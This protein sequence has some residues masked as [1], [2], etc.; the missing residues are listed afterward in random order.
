MTS[1]Q[2]K[3]FLTVAKMLSFT[4][5]AKSLYMAQPALSKQISAFEKELQMQLFDR[6]KRSVKLTKQGEI[7]YEELSA[8]WR[9]ME[10]VVEMAKNIDKM[11]NAKMKVGV[12]ADDLASN[13]LPKIV[14]E[15]GRSMPEAE[16]DVQIQN[17]SV[18]RTGLDDGTF[19]LVLMMDFEIKDREDIYSDRLAARQLEF[20]IGK[21]S[22]LVRNGEPI[23]YETLSKEAF[24]AVSDDNF[25]IVDKWFQKKREGLG[26]NPREILYAPNVA[27]QRLWLGAGKGAALV[28][29]KNTPWLKD[30]VRVID[31]PVGDTNWLCAAWKKE[32]ENP[33]IH[34]FLEIAQDI[35]A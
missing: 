6:T 22:E 28:D 4:E 7:M 13:A 21:E 18:L 12:V 31:L 2:I 11:R 27:T 19:D 9:R 32:N 17:S 23:N 29:L 30:V 33:L 34:Y 14:Y 10:M 35:M 16:L 3:C 15:F 24:I 20:V 26:Y 25:D 8:I 1:V 5:A